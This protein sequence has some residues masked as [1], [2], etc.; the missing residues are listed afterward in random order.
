MSFDREDDTAYLALAAV[1]EADGERS[2][3][4]DDCFDDP[5]V[6]C[7][8]RVDVDADGRMFGI[9]W[10]EDAPEVIRPDIRYRPGDDHVLLWFV[11]IGARTVATTGRLPEAA[12]VP[13]DVDLHFDADGGLIGIEAHAASTQ[14]PAALLEGAAAAAP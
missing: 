4:T 10:P 9:E 6:V 7:E 2:V 11:G 14:L 1:D 5:G 12:G 8:A 3:S 13:G